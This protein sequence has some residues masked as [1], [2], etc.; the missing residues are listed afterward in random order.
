LTGPAY[1]VSHGGEEFPNLIIVL[2]G[3]GVRV[4]LTGDT[5][6]NE[7]TGITSS[8]FKLVPDVPVDTFELYLPQGK[9][10]ALAANTNLCKT[11]HAMPTAFTAQNG[12]TLDRN[13]RIA[14][15]GCAKKAKRASTAR[16]HHRSKHARAKHASVVLGGASSGTRTGRGQ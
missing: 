3:D 15:T 1:F 11:K 7:K 13:T 14:V 10:H 2:Q 4:N 5:F 8:T 6:I 16:K 12:L 9:Y